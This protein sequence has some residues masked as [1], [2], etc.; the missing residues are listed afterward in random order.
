MGDAVPTELYGSEAW[1]MRIAEGRKVNV[2]EM[3]VFEKFVWSVTNGL[4]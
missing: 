2:L 3:I 1:G 4:S